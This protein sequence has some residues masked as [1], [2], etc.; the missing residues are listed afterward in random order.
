M[1]YVYMTLRY[2]ICVFSWE[3]CL[4][5]QIQDSTV[6]SSTWSDLFCC[7]RKSYTHIWNHDCMVTYVPFL[8]HT[9]YMESQL[10]IPYER[11]A[12][13]GKMEKLVNQ[14]PA[15]F[16]SGGP[17]CKTGL[18][19]QTRWGAKNFKMRRFRSIYDQMS[20][21]Y[22]IVSNCMGSR[23]QFRLSQWATCIL[24]CKKL[25]N[26]LCILWPIFLT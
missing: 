18:G 6:W 4:G 23:V 3:V 13:A 20:L 24:K 22:E 14:E 8:S 9:A 12:D 26:I 25:H 1:Q 11:H 21:I 7:I 2:A 10:K 19:R 5:W 16:M 17:S 15:S